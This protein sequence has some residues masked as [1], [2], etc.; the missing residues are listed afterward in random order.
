MENDDRINSVINSVGTSGLAIG[1][2]NP[3]AL[4]SKEGYAYRVTGMDQI[5]DIINCGFVRTKGYGSRRERVGEVV[6]WSIG[7]KVCYYD[8]R[9]VIEVPLDKVYDGQIGAVS[10]D[11][12]SAIWLFDEAQ[13]SYVNKIA[14]IRSLYVE[15]QQA[16]GN[17]S[18]GRSR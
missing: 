3:M 11:D 9:P 12:L 8:K 5:E 16:L 15:R 17:N 13:N 6:Y 10:I 14:D 18:F 7:G 4:K 2:N 1:R